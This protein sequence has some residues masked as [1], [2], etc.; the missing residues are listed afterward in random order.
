MAVLAVTSV[1]VNTV[2]GRSATDAAIADQSLPITTS[3]PGSTLDLSVTPATT[4]ANDLHLIYADPRGRPVLVQGPVRVELSL[5]SEDL[6][7]IT[8]T[9]CWPDPGTT[10]SRAPTSAPP[11]PGRS[12]W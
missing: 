1:L 5:P 8:A 12:P 7:P 11:E 2:P 10:S 6:G 3:T 4:G 9:R